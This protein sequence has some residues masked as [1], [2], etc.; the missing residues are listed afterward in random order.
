MWASVWC[1][2]TSSATTVKPYSTSY[3][4]V[5]GER[6]SDPSS[7]SFVFRSHLIFDLTEPNL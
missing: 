1:A 6:V 2:S 4:Q 5:S 3:P 7:S